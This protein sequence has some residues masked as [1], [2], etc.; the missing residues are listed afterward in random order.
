MVYEYGA[1]KIL[2]NIKKIFN[3]SNKK[4]RISKIR[5]ETFDSKRIFLIFQLC[6]SFLCHCMACTFLMYSMSIN[7]GIH[8]AGISDW[9]PSFYITSRF[10]FVGFFNSYS[11]WSS[12]NQS[13]DLFPVYSSTCHFSERYSSLKLHYAVVWCH[14]FNYFPKEYTGGKYFC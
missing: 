13:N 11:S 7:L 2:L 9:H 6:T 4:S 10:V 8:I 14:L 12:F 5:T 3:D 1:F